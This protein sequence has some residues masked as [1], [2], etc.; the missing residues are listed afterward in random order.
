MQ[1]GPYPPPHGGVAANVAALHD[2]LGEHGIHCE[3][4]SLSRR[5]QRPQQNVHCPRGALGV[6]L[7][8]LRLRYEVVHLHVGGDLTPREI[9]LAFLCCS[10]PWSRTVLTFHSGG[11]P[12]SEEGRRTGRNSVRALALR[13]FD[14]LVAVNEEIAE[15][16]RRVGVA[17]ERILVISPFGM[18]D[19][20][21]ESIMATDIDTVLS[22][23]LLT[24]YH[25]HDP[26][27]TT[28]GGLEPEYDLPTQ[29]DAVE[30]VLKR[31]P[32]AGLMVIGDG[33][34]RSRIED[35]VRRSSYADHICICGDVRHQ[36]AMGLLA[37]SDLFLRTTLYDGDA[38]SVREALRLGTPVV[39]T[40]N[41]MRPEG[42]HLVPIS[43]PRALGS[44]VVDVLASGNVTRGAAKPTGLGEVLDLY[45][46]LVFESSRDVG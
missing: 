28:I 35:Q 42:V 15:F 34:L 30:L 23:Q 40:D 20:Q 17:Q 37:K 19:R 45:S 33:S 31:Y 38:I 12:S 41:G 44:K 32:E 26:V 1:L 43:D 3:V 7:L 36:E 27:L 11:Y 9:L 39:A 14:A 29:I 6:L 18:S 4:V 22:D 46:E 13:Q 5:G 10:F 8:L 21:V 2:Y 16:F 25:S 24:F